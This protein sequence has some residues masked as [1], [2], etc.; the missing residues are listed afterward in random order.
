MRLLIKL[1]AYGA[2]GYLVYEFF[3]GLAY[4][5]KSGGSQSRSKSNSSGSQSRG[6]EDLQRALNDDEQGRAG[7]LTG[8]GR[9]FV[10]RTE[11]ADGASSPHQVGRG[12]IRG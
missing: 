6:S 11:A 9:G 12:V 7:M 4:G 2:L 8:G 5:S 3:N 1:A 10:E